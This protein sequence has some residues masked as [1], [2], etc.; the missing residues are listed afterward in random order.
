[1]EKLIEAIEPIK[2]GEFPHSEG[3]FSHPALASLCCV[4]FEN[5]EKKN[6][7]KVARRSIIEKKKQNFHE[8]RFCAASTQQ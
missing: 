5:R 3:Q 7:V 8:L 2:T 1:M 4:F 6:L